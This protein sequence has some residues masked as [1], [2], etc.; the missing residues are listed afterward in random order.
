MSGRII[1]IRHGESEWNEAGLFAG[2]TDIALT[3]KGED[4]ARQTA[5]LLCEHDVTVDTAFSS[6]LVRAARTLEIIGQKV[7]IQQK[8]Y[9]AEL[10]ERDYAQFTG[11]NKAGVKAIHGDRAYKTLRRG[12]DTRVGDAET[13]KEV[14]DRT[15]SWF[16]AHAL[17]LLREGQTVLV[18][19]H[20]N[21]LRSLTAH[22]QGNTPEELAEIELGTAEAHV[23]KIDFSE[24]RLSREVIK[25]GGNAKYGKRA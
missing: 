8:H 5:E 6:R 10:R 16:E 25:L 24:S 15:M 23:H 14:Y 13:G 21:P 18:V 2:I 3:S 17:P 9:H 7:P 22:L 4:E 1:L 20:H 11:M 19:S 12:W